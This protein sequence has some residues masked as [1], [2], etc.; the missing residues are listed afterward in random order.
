MSDEFNPNAP[1]EFEDDINNLIS[2]LNSQFGEGRSRW[3]YDEPTE[4]LFI[5]LESIARL[6]DE[7]IGEKAEP[8]FDNSELD[9]EEIVLLP[10][11]Y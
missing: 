8:V 4:T 11:T 5:E 10:L 1:E 9:F 6:D 7:E 3:Y 2:E